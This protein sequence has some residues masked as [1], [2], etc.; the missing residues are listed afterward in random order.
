MLSL[1]FVHQNV[2]NINK[3]VCLKISPFSARR[4]FYQKNS[5]CKCYVCGTLLIDTFPL[6]LFLFLQNF[7]PCTAEAKLKAK[8]MIS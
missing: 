8:V 3:I 4:R 2:M 5:V 1:G 7:H 6:G